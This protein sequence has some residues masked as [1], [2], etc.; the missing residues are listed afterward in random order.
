MEGWGESKDLGEILVL[1]NLIWHIKDTIGSLNIP[2][3]WPIATTVEPPV[4]DHPNMR[5]FSAL[6]WEMVAYENGI[7]GSGAPFSCVRNTSTFYKRIRCT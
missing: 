3:K 2:M 7:K 6:L 5:R 1:R 4:N